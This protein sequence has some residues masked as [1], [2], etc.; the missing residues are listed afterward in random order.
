[1]AKKSKAAPRMR[2][3]AIMVE[4]ETSLTIE[5][6]K[7]L[8]SLVFLSLKGRGRRSIKLEPPT[9]ACRIAVSDCRGAIRQVQVNVIK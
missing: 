6:L 3:V 8:K 7:Q 4:A 1:M 5:Q 2:K 9:Q